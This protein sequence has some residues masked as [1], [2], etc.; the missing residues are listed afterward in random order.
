MNKP[1]LSVVTANYNHAHFLPDAIEAIIDQSFQPKEYIIIDD[2]STDNSIEVIRSYMKKSSIITLL[3]NNK[4]MGTLYSAGKG[5]KHASGDYLYFASADDKIYPGFF[6]KSMKIFDC[7][8]TAGF[9]SSLGSIINNEGLET[10]LIKSRIKLGKSR[11]LAP[12]EVGRMLCK[13]GPWFTG[14]TTIYK[15]EYLI[16]VGGM[17][18]ELGPYWDGFITKVIALRYGANFIPEV[19]AAWRKMDSGYALETLSNPD[20]W[21]KI[22]L[23]AVQLMRTK[24]SNLFPK[25]YTTEFEKRAIYNYGISSWNQNKSKVTTIMRKLWL[26]LNYSPSKLEKIMVAGVNLLGGISKYVFNLYM[27]FRYRI[28]KTLIKKRLINNNNI[29]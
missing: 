7:H 11:Y 14:N 18:S 5:L 1:T 2:G 3:K 10:G 21:I 13:F 22:Q 28:S 6:E 8:P 26:I 15:R 24:Y 4:N 23:H 20:E 16:E 29:K 27:F 9:C 25:E 12:E 19:L 17:I